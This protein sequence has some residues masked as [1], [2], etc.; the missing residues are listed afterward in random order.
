ML[1]RS[2]GER[3]PDREEAREGADL[4]IY[5][6]RMFVRHLNLSKA[7]EFNDTAGIQPVPGLRKKHLYPK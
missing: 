3:G 4:D 2:R 5:V 7:T 6:S 1:A